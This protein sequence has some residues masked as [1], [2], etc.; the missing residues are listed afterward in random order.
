M[1]PALTV[2]ANELLAVH[3][4]RR[5]S[6]SV[7]NEGEDKAHVPTTL[8]QKKEQARV[9]CETAISGGSQSTCAAP[10]ERTETLGVLKRM[11]AVCARA[12]AR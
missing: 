1:Q 9:F 4:P 7:G 11:N 12:D 10:D 8:A 5:T 2:F 3:G 6:R